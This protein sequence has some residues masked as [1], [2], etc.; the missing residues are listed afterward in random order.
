MVEIPTADITSPT[1]EDSTPAF[2][3]GKYGFTAEEFPELE[4]KSEAE[5]LSFIISALNQPSEVELPAP[6]PAP[7]PPPPSDDNFLPALAY[8]ADTAQAALGAGIKAVGQ[9]FNL[10]SLEEYGRDLEEK[11]LKEAE[12]S[13]KQYTQIRLD[14]VDFGENTTDF[15]IQTLGETLP[16]MGIAAAGAAVGAVGAAATPVAALTAT[17]G[18][19]AGAFLPSSLL[20]AGEVQLKMQNLTGDSDYEDPFTAMGGGLIIGALDTAAAAIPALKFLGK[21]FTEKATTE[22]LEKSGIDFVVSRNGTATAIDE[23]KK[24]GGDFAKAEANIIAAGRDI[25]RGRLASGGIEGTKQLAREGLTE[26]T[27]EAIGTLLAEGSTGIEDEEFLSSI[28]ESAVKGG[29]AGFGPGAVVGALKGGKT[30]TEEEKSTEEAVAAPAYDSNEVRKIR[31]DYERTKSEQEKREA[32][33][34]DPAALAARAQETGETVESQTD[35]VRTNYE[36]NIDTLNELEQTVNSSEFQAAEQARD[37]EVASKDIKFKDITETQIENE[38]VPAVDVGELADTMNLRNRDGQ[39][40]SESGDGTAAFINEYGEL[41]REFIDLREEGKSRFYG[42]PRRTEGVQPNLAASLA[43]RTDKLREMEKI[44]RTPQFQASLK[45]NPALQER[46]DNI[47]AEFYTR[48]EEF[49]AARLPPGVVNEVDILPDL[50]D[51]NDNLIELQPGVPIVTQEAATFYVDDLMNAPIPEDPNLLTNLPLAQERLA[52]VEHIKKQIPFLRVDPTSRVELSPRR[53]EQVDIKFDPAEVKAPTAFDIDMQKHKKNLTDAANNKGGRG[54]LDDNPPNSVNFDDNGPQGMLN[55]VGMYMRFM[56]SN[57]RIADKFPE[58]RKTYNLVKRYN[59]TWFSIITQGIE[60]RNLVLALP[61][62]EPRRK[63]R[64][65]RTK[66]D[67]ISQ[68]IKFEGAGDL[69]AASVARIY[70]VPP[71]AEQGLSLAQKLAQRKEYMDQIMPYQAYDPHSSQLNL[72]FTPEEIQ[73][74]YIE[75][76][77]QA[78]VDALFQ[79]QNTANAM[80]DNIIASRIRSIKRKLTEAD[81]KDGSAYSTV[82]YIESVEDD[83]LLEGFRGLPEGSTKEDVVS[84]LTSFD[85]FLAALERVNERQ[86]LI[87]EKQGTP[88]GISKKAFDL[89]PSS[90]I[91]MEGV[92]EGRRQGFFP[93]MRMGDIIIRVFATFTE[94]DK[95]GKERTFRKV[96]YRRDVNAPL[97]RTLR[98]DQQPMDWVKKKYTDPLESFYKEKGLDVSVEAVSRGSQNYTVFADEELSDISILEAILIHEAKLNEDFSGNTTLWSGVTR[99]MD[100]N[101]IDETVKTS[102]DF[103]KL[104]VKQRRDRLQGQ[105]F[106]GSLMRRKNIPGYITPENVNS[107]HDNAW[108]QYVVSMGRYVAKND[109]EDEI[110]SELQRLNSLDQAV[111]KGGSFVNVAN[112]MWQNT[113][114]PQG[115]AS[116]LKSLAFY[117]FLG[118]NFSSS[119]LNLTQNFVTAALLFGAYGKIFQPKVAKAAAAATRLSIYYQRKQAFLQADKDNVSKILLET[120][121]ARNLTEANEQFNALY[122]LQKRGSIGRINT[123]ALNE[124]ADLTTEYWSEKLGLNNLEQKVS[125]RV[126]AKNVERFKDYAKTGKKIIDGVYSTTEVANRIAAALATY[127]TV[128]AH[129]EQQLKGSTDQKA[130]VN[131]GLEPMVQF[132]SETA[133]QGRIVTIEDA[134]Q[135]IIDESQFNLSAFNR[136]R[137]AFEGK[138]IGGVT[139]QFIPFVTM[140]TEVYA[141]AIH[142]YGGNKYGTIRGGVLNMTPQGK[143]TLA[144]LVLP[145]VIMGGMF[146]LP[147]ADDMKEVIKA[148]IRSPVGVSLGLQQS[149]LELAFYDIMTDIFGPEALSYAE[150]IARGPIKSWGGI[151]ISQR[152]SLSP[153]RTLI[154]AGTGQASV[155]ELVSGP[156]G[157]FFT[158]AIGKSFD[159]FERGDLGKALLRLA[160]LAVVQNMINAWEAGEMGVATG[161]GRILTDSLGP[162]D[163]AAMTLG[164]ATESVY[165]P[166]QEL[167]RLKTYLSKS[168]AIK[169]YYA[170]KILRLMVKQKNTSSAEE[171][172]EIG[173]EIEKL[174]KDVVDHDLKQDQ[175][176]DRIDPNFNLRLTVHKRYADQVL[177]LEKYG[178]GMEEMETRQKENIN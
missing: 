124:N 173:N 116:A 75:E 110:N 157:A 112:S 6:T 172:A 142:K 100:G 98:S 81:D 107:Y 34:N 114:S 140:M 16:S 10:E 141:N 132:A 41:Q 164:F 48:Q 97:W 50:R 47:R 133:N 156:S 120:G 71:E 105:G 11:N 109:V 45:I 137:I 170:D 60:G 139:L 149:D 130:I 152:V 62:G 59:E 150:G 26:G 86:R 88:R 36:N 74:G 121:A 61:R 8:G 66:A 84:E 29:I 69:S 13:A 77:D 27:Q 147:F 24:A 111:E 134:M 178:G 174:F 161:K 175:M 148:I 63:Y 4:G 31:A 162:K 30:K 7:V 163:L 136:P 22:A 138:G 171:K 146:G 177:G 56:S 106:R 28:L 143:R 67:M 15:I 55:R 127:N 145:Q 42:G 126:D 58:L 119:I 44:I 108:A 93:R 43:E 23:L 1:M 40:F 155:T 2:D 131:A 65:M 91:E 72:N 115:G 153:F 85:L 25:N 169:D 94:K 3:I 80:W 38:E 5:V 78:V 165:V 159:A 92:I 167:Y 154:E 52:L 35:I 151:D 168:N 54:Q 144:F 76:T 82:R 118:G 70:I 21:G 166:R 49:N 96:V 53:F 176:S 14:D 90:I 95:N 103:I 101:I 83:I 68:P 57:K 18:A 51:L 12:E 87:Q 19:L 64:T 117:G 128:K 158:N 9:G 129:G 46:L 113:K 33:L 20:G 89:L 104:L 123:Q 160:P 102:D 73:R 17:G 125:S 99:D 122:E 135:Y 39:Q 79:E 32:L 37:E